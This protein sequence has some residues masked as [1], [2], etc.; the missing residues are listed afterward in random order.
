MRFTQFSQKKN[1]WTIKLDRF[2]YVFYQKLEFTIWSFSDE[3][4]TVYDL[5]ILIFMIHLEIKQRTNHWSIGFWNI[6][7]GPGNGSSKNPTISN[8]KK[9]L[10]SQH[11]SWTSR[12]KVLLKN[13]W[14]TFKIISFCLCVS[15]HQGPTLENWN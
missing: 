11:F 5:E 12:Q 2:F 6:F 1:F 8:C 13:P 10:I 9:R 15:Q 4:Y 14:K 3:S 7:L